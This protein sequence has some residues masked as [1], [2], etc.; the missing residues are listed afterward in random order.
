MEAGKKL[1]RYG[2]EKVLEALKSLEAGKPAAEIAREYGVHEWTVYRWRQ[3]YSGVSHSEISRL[4]QLEGE[5]A[6]LKRVVA[7][8]ALD[9]ASL[10]ELLSKKW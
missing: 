1:K 4:R 6:K 5:N 2:A 10:K 9:I 3:R 7:D 8:Q